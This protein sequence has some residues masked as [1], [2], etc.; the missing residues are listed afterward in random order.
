MKSCARRVGSS[1]YK[2][3]SL[4]VITLIRL[5]SQTHQLSPIFIKSKGKRLLFGLLASIHKKYTSPSKQGNLVPKN[6]VNTHRNLDLSLLLERNLLECPMSMM[7][8]W[9]FAKVHGLAEGGARSWITK[10]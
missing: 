2:V 4:H 9:L 1:G 10:V 6:V 3:L 5:N 8:H 7:W